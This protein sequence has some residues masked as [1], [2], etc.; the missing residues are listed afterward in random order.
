MIK[1]R[2]GVTIMQEDKIQIAPDTW[3]YVDASHTKLIVEI[4]LPK[5]QQGKTHQELHNGGF[6]PGKEFNIAG[7]MNLCL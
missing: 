4:E 5:E 6:T 2:K 3:I 1:K 7:L